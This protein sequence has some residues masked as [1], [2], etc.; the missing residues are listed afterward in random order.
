MHKIYLLALPLSLAMGGV[1]ATSVSPGT[2]HTLV[3]SFT[4]EQ[5]TLRSKLTVS[6]PTGFGAIALAA[7]Q[8]MNIEMFGV[9]NGRTGRLM[10]SNI[11][12]TDANFVTEALASNFSFNT[13]TAV[14]AG[15][16]ENALKV[17]KRNSGKTGWDNDGSKEVKFTGALLKTSFSDSSL[18]NKTAVFTFASANQYTGSKNVKLINKSANK[19]GVQLKKKT[20]PTSND[21]LEM[22]VQMLCGKHPNHPTTANTKGTSA[23][24]SSGEFQPDNT[25]ATNGT[26]IDKYKMS[27]LGG[28]GSANVYNNTISFVPTELV[29][30]SNTVAPKGGTYVGD[31]KVTITVK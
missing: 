25:S 14:K 9:T 7:N 20:S 6:H 15:T 22:T 27:L 13:A 2:A 8:S 21:V 1:N 3:G 30:T 26:G 12:A 11:S 5:P 31:L 29:A 4:L 10:G 24:C 17:K 19:I 16:F 18:D 23:A 28:H